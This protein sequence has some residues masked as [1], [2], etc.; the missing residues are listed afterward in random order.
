[1]K[2]LDLAKKRFSLR[3]Y[4][5]REVEAE[6]LERILMAGQAAPTAKNFQPQHI[7]VLKGENIQK[8]A[9]ASPCTYGA[10][11]VLIVCYDK[12][13]VASLPEMNQVNFGYVDTACIIT[14]MMLQA[15]AL[16]L[17]TCWVGCFEEQKMREL[18]NIPDNLV[19]A[20][21]LD[22]G[23]PGANGV[24]SERHPQCK[25]LSDTVEYL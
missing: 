3:D 10:P 20:A 4:A 11:V 15:T 17:G 9:E 14:H 22:I 24:P 8:A 13:Q 25:P 16:G 6:K 7:Y 19:I 21:L 2:F 12:D 23:Y 18:F 1:M 5:D